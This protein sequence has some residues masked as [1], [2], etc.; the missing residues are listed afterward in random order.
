MENQPI[1]AT[2]YG[3]QRATNE[4]FGLQ[5]TSSQ[6]QSENK[7]LEGFEAGKQKLGRKRLPLKR[8]AEIHRNSSFNWKRQ[9]KIM[10]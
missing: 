10:H 1:K 3:R 6:Q 2:T 5:R 8:K 7:V 4:N 9:K